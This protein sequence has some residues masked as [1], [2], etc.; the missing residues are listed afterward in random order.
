MNNCLGG[1][2][3]MFLVWLFVLLLIFSCLFEFISFFLFCYFFEI[4]LRSLCL[5]GE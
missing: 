2:D 3:G 1:S 5:I 4:K